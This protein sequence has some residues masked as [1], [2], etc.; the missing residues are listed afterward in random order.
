LGQKRKADDQYS[1]NPHTVKAR[2]RLERMG[3]HE[4]A[5]QTAQ[6]ADQTAIVRAQRKLKKSS[7][8]ERMNELE[9][10][11]ALANVR[12]QVL[13]RRYLPQ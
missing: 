1:I 7:E 5:F 6:S 3:P 11:D 10:Q 13:E 9:Q 12:D 8:F 2:K 4:R